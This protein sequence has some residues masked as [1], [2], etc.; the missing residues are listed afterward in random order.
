M[1][2]ARTLRHE[3]F[4]RSDAL[5]S[6]TSVAKAIAR[7]VVDHAGSLHESVADGRSDES[8]AAAF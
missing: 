1:R 7:V 8:E 3:H 4:E 5:A 2:D 6:M